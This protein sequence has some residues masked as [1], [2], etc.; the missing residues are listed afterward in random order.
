MN[1][2]GKNVHTEKLSNLVLDM[3]Q[4]IN[5][6]TEKVEY[7]P[8]GIPIIQSK[9][10]TKGYLHFN[11]AKFLSKEAYLKYKDKYQP[12][13]D[14][15]LV[16]NIGTIGKSLRIS[17][18][19]PFLIAW[20]LFLIKIKKEHLF[21]SFFAHYLNYLADKKY[22]DRFLTG[23]TVK[24]INKKTMGNIPVP[25]PPLDQQKQIANILDTADAYRQK[26][27]ALIDKYDALTQSLFLDMFGDPV[28]NPK[29]WETK[30][31]EAFTLKYNQGVNTTTEK[32]KYSKEG[33][34]PIVRAGEVGKG[35]L[36]FD[37]VVFVDEENESRI[38]DTCKPVFGDVL[39][40]NIGANLGTAC[41]V[42]TTKKFG[43]AWN[44]FRIQ[45]KDDVNRM[46]FVHQ[47]NSEWIRRVIWSKV[48]TAT[49]P[50]ISGKQIAVMDFINPPQEIQNQFAERVKAIEAQKAL[51]QQEL[52]K[53]DELFNSLLQ[54]AFKGELKHK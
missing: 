54:K 30:K 47:L 17:D 48:K 38:K 21:S 43:I 14:D 27:K 49:V 46:F 24:F 23:G 51:A 31:F 1:L 52:D 39:Y 10:I 6:V 22:Y 40:A 50:F 25:L 53:A 3:H 44:V 8:E 28:T 7:L 20:N 42:E 35:S 26:T 37:S 2:V 29:G 15:L 13:L 11:D 33:T 18:D 16:C 34:F 5:T 19:N 4:G 45:L 32:I 12:K 41:L 36:N 9:H